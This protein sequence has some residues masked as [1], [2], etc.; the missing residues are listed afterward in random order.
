MEKN[1]KQKIFRNSRNKI[2]LTIMGL[3]T[4][5]LV[6]TLLTIYATT[7]LTV[8]RNNQIM[9]L[10]FAQEYQSGRVQNKEAEEAGQQEKAAA[11]P[12]GNE[13][14]KEKALFSENAFR[15]NSVLYMVVFAENGTV[16]ETMNDIQPIMS[17]AD[18]QKTAWK[19]ATDSNR[20]GVSQNL[21]YR[22]T[23]I[24]NIVSGESAIYVVM[25]DNTLMHDSMT[26]LV[27][28]AL[29]FG[30]VALVFL[31]L[32]SVYLAGRIV[33]PME[34]A[35]QKQK[36]FISDASH[37]LK[38]PISTVDANA[39]LLKREVGENRWLANIIFE[40]QRMENIVKL[41]LDLAK[42]ENTEPVWEDVDFSH[43]VMGGVLPFD[44]IAFDKGF[45]LDTKILTGI[46][47]MGDSRQLGQLV[48]TLTD[49]AISHASDFGDKGQTAGEQNIIS[50]SLIKEDGSA[51]LRVTNPGKPISIEE[52]DKI[53]ERFY[54]SDSSRELNDHYGLGLAIAKAIAI[55]HNGQISCLS[56]GNNNTFAVKIPLK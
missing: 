13:Q 4:A 11:A 19:F 45:I 26:A 2:V 52:R 35:Y 32:V 12:A 15:K 18:L 49:N 51:V 5:V 6:G 55:A 39:E 25:M 44:S 33:Q 28:N 17:D 24:K 7:Y 38:T 50:I 8:Y 20:D 3:L 23:T 22:A 42:T 56:E 27:Q 43:I 1:I 34:E 14:V 9:L 29:I 40:N 54:R 31:F 37:E 47:V 41:L 36:Q 46:H 16:L 21:I 48:S 10:K 53:F 30:F